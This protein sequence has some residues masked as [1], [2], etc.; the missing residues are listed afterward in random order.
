MHQLAAAPVDVSGALLGLVLNAPRA[1]ATGHHRLALTAALQLGVLGASS[2]TVGDAFCEE[3]SCVAWRG[4]DLPGVPG[5]HLNPIP[6]RT[7]EAAFG[8]SRATC[9]NAARGAG[10]GGVF[11]GTMT[12]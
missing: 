12:R 1:A 3:V 2:V 4:G 7:T 5:Y 8:D 9:V 11:P 10:V 6:R